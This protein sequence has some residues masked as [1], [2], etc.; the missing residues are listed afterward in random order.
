MSDRLT[1][2]AIS[3]APLPRAMDVTYAYWFAM[4]AA[5]ALGTN[6]GDLWAEILFPGRF[7]SLA[8]LLAICAVAVWYDRR[9]AARTE[10]GYWVAIVVMRAAATNL[11]DI[12]THDLAMNYVVA[13]ALLA[14][15]TLVAARFTRPDPVRGGSPLVDGAYWMAMFVAGLFGTVAGDFIHHSI[16]LYAASGLLCL[17]LAGLIVTRNVAAS[18]SMLLYWAIVMAERCAGT[19]VGDALASRRAVGL[20]VL[21]AT[22]CTTVLTLDAL[23]MRARFWRQPRA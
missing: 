20:G 5:S 9:A 22:V 13:S 15:L 8:S 21:I 23:W 7:S 14:V 17:A 19:A 6:L 11:A 18:T 16:G 12:I 3:A 10:A 4:L 1:S 2:S